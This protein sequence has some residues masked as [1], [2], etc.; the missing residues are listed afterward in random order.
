MILKL[1]SVISGSPSIDADWIGSPEWGSNFGLQ[2]SAR[3]QETE[4]ASTP[5]LAVPRHA[6]ESD[7]AL[8]C[9]EVPR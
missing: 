7:W 1:P 9:M 6:P 8:D 4:E 2:D 5:C 3:N